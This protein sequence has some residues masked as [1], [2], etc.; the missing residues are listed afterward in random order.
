MAAIGGGGGS[1]TVVPV[2]WL[3]PSDGTVAEGPHVD[4]RSIPLVHCRPPGAGDRHRAPIVYAHGNAEDLGQVVDWCR[5]L[6]Q[7]LRRSVYVYDYEGYGLNASTAT[8]RSVYDN[9]ASVVTYLTTVAGVRRLVL[10]GRSIGTAPALHEAARGGGAGGAVCGVVLQSAFKSVVST[11]LPS[12][13]VPRWCDILFNNRDIVACEV[14]VLLVH[15]TEDHI[16]PFGHALALN[17][18][19][20]VWGHCW[21][22]GAGHNDIELTV[23]GDHVYEHRALRVHGGP[24]GRPTFVGRRVFAAAPRSSA[25][26]ARSMNSWSSPSLSWCK[27]RIAFAC[28]AVTSIGPGSTRSVC[29]ADTTFSAPVPPSDWQAQRGSQSHSLSSAL[30]QQLHLSHSLHGP[31]SAAVG[32]TNAFSTIAAISCIFSDL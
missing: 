28:A 18:A 10:Y 1:G 22:K 15:G 8:E 21:L 32:G 24:S 27:P 11:Y 4:A 26:N 16:V 6:S 7:R 12:K 14:P 25:H 23:P 30:H 9:I 5:F 19:K 17:R 29:P 3:H 31:I 2:V 20:C 13:V